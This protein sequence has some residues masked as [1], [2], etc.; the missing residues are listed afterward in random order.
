MI[1]AACTAFA[2]LV[3][4]RNR[5]PPT[6]TDGG[7]CGWEYRVWA[8]GDNTCGVLGLSRCVHSNLSARD[9]TF[10]ACTEILFCTLLAWMVRT[11]A[12]LEELPETSLSKLDTRWHRAFS[13]LVSVCHDLMGAFGKLFVCSAVTIFIAAGGPEGGRAGLKERYLGGRRRCVKDSVVHEALTDSPGH[14]SSG[15]F[16]HL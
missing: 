2:T 9:S 5:P 8:F 6:A 4:T 13:A 7:G 15:Y 10:L 12:A 14:L 11:K 16:V 3:L 1:D